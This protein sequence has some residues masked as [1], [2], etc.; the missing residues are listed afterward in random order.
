MSTKKYWVETLLKNKSQLET[1]EKVYLLL[2]DNKESY[3][4]HDKVKDELEIVQ[5]D[6][7]A[8][9]K[10]LKEIESQGEKWNS[11]SSN[12]LILLYAR[13]EKENISKIRELLH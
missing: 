9:N 6:L 13:R 12:F 7:M 3:P 2:I 4:I 8:I 11:Q 10:D 5:K 1:I